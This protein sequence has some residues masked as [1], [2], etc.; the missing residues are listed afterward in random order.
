MVCSQR[1]KIVFFG[2]LLSDNGNNLCVA[3]EGFLF[4][5][6]FEAGEIVG[7]F[8]LGG[9]EAHALTAAVVLVGVLLFLFWLG[10]EVGGNDPGLKHKFVATGGSTR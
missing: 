3:A 1:S 10:I 8:V 2:E 5:W 9:T 6:V 7:F 4:E